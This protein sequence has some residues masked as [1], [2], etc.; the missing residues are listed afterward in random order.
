MAL[1]SR[2]PSR[3]KDL[4]FGTLRKLE[5]ICG[6]RVPNM[7]KAVTVMF[8]HI[9][10]HFDSDHES[11]KSSYPG[12]SLLY[13]K[14]N[15]TLTLIKSY[16]TATATAYG[17]ITINPNTEKCCSFSWIFR[18]ISRPDSVRASLRAF[19]IG[20]RD[21]ITI[22]PMSPKWKYDRQLSKG[23]V[24]TMTLCFDRND[25]YGGSMTFCVNSCKPEVT[26]TDLPKKR[27]YRMMV[28]ITSGF[29]GDYPCIQLMD[30]FEQ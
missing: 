13:D 7:I 3:S 27:T 29:G 12:A 21:S 15:R 16:I 20:I 9:D 18:I 25:K 14:E 1:L 22:G 24:I 10:E 11:H 17:H 2:V 28:N 26:F 5:E 23:D 8:Y 4:I 30:Y 19:E 6:V